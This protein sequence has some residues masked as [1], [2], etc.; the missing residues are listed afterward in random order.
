MISGKVLRQHCG[1]PIMYN[2]KNTNALADKRPQAR[3]Q[4]ITESWG[5][6]R[7]DSQVFSFIADETYRSFASLRMTG[8]RFAVI[9]SEA[10]DLYATSTD[11]IIPIAQFP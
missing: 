5:M 2:S 9:L 3:L 11:C 7:R 10:K 6:K 8:F 4:L 1:P